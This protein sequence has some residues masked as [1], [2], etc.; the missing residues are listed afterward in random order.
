MSADNSETNLCENKVV[1]GELLYNGIRLPA[2]W[3]PRGLDP[4]AVQPMPVPYL[5]TPP[6]VIPIDVG[7]QLFVDDFLIEHTT[8]RREFHYPEK[9]AGNPILQP[10]TDLERNIP[11]CSM[12]GPKSGGMWWDSTEKVFKLWYEAGW[13]N[14]ICYAESEDGLYWRRPNLDIR[15]GT[16]QVLPEGVQPD[17]WSV[18]KDYWCRDPQQRYKLFM[19]EPGGGND[20]GA[21]CY[22]SPDGIHWSKPVV[23]GPSGDRSTAFFNPFRRKWVYSLRILQEGR[24]LRYYH[25]ADDFLDGAAWQADE[26]VFWTAADCLDKADP[27]IGDIPQLYNLDAVAY[28]SIMLGFYQIHLGPAN[29][30]CKEKGLPKI[31]ELNFAYS[32]DGFHWSRPD[33]TPAIR[34]ERRDVWDR[35]YIQP[36]GN[37]CTVRGDKLWFYYI[38]FQGRTETTD[39]DTELPWNGM[40]DNGATGIAFLRRDGFASMNA[41]NET[42]TLQTRTLIFKGHYLFVNLDAPQGFLRAEILDVDNNPI[43]PFT[44]D[45]CCPASGDSTLLQIKWKADDNLSI[46]QNKPVKLRFEL[47]NGKLY[48]F[49]ISRDQSGR[50]DGYVTG[51]GP[52]FTGPTDT[53]GQ[54]S[55]DA[56]KSLKI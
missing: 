55:L 28:E 42:S 53:V 11:G 37:L 39:N 12:A 47:N 15:P 21:L 56:E 22:V 40:Y 35:G 29:Q 45:N 50:S 32:R 3:P 20:K 48:A 25:E 16:N 13:L 52:G 10:E 34:A 36:L 14:T 51:G 26:P 7:R 1:P 33:R 30:V 2:E 49:W 46:L 9:Y 27:E 18:I 5:E 23:S 19:R 4:N 6:A 8:L 38:G 41:L 43:A 54:S 24:R 17:S 44:L 31:T